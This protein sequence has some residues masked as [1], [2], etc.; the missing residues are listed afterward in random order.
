MRGESKSKNDFKDLKICQPDL[1]RLALM[2][3]LVFLF[4]IYCIYQIF[5]PSIPDISIS[6]SIESKVLGN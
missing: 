3:H 4:L 1:D 2:L 6:G 5:G